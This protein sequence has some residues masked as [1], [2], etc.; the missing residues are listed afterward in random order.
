MRSREV[1]ASVRAVAAVEPDVRADV[2]GATRRKTVC[3]AGLVHDEQPEAVHRCLVDRDRAR[4]D[5]PADRLL[6]LVEDLPGRRGAGRADDPTGRQG[7]GAAR[8]LLLRRR[9][10]ERA[11]VQRNRARRQRRVDRSRVQWIGL[12]HRR[13]PAVQTRLS[14][15]QRA[16]ILP[17][18]VELALVGRQEVEN[19][20]DRNRKRKHHHQRDDQRLPRLRI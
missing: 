11:L 18:T 17:V 7:V 15:R 3:V 9:V 16:L 8:R 1:D 19:P 2:G 4:L 20:G 14:D 13:K 10:R 5:D 12:R 6:Q